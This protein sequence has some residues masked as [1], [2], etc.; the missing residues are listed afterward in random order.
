[1]SY[2]P[3]TYDDSIQDQKELKL[4]LNA[5]LVTVTVLIVCFII[6]LMCN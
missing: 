6:W 5:I 2:D 4:V 1:M 3:D